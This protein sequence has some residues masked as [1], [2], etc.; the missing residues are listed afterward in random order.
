[1][2]EDDPSGAPRVRDS[3]V[4]SQRAILGR[5]RLVE[6]VQ[7]EERLCFKPPPFIVV[8]LQCDGVLRR[9]QRIL[10]PTEMLQKAALAMPGRREGGAEVEGAV[11]RCQ[12]LLIAPRSGQDVR[13]RGPCSSVLGVEADRNV[14]GG[15]SIVVA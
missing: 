12:R 15:Q 2:T 7:R 11:A 3:R 10:V 1:M 8:R 14:T 4:E 6:T 13:T 5:E 9:F